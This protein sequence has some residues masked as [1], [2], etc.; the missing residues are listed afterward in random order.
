MQASMC[1]LAPEPTRMKMD[2]FILKT[3]FKKNRY[4]HHP[5]YV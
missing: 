5:F 4:Y 1:I 3:K 2:L